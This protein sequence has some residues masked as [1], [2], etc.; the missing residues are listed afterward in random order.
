M[1]K[2]NRTETW[3]NQSM[4]HPSLT[5]NAYN[6]ILDYLEQSGR[7]DTKPGIPE[8]HRQIHAFL[9][10]GGTEMNDQA[11]G[12]LPGIIGI[13]SGIYES[14][15]RGEKPSIPQ[16]TLLMDYLYR[17]FDVRVHYRH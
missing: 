5:L 17:Y 7:S 14:V 2:L 4:D 16:C 11:R 13:S 6:K 9:Y 15:K 1:S 12:V 8:L 3:D 10:F